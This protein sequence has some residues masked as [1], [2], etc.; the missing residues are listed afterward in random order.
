[1]SKSFAAY[2]VTQFLDES[3]GTFIDD[4]WDKVVDMADE[5][6]K[7]ERLYLKTQIEYLVEQCKDVIR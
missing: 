7:D 3:I 6:D 5:D 1:M 4:I 2:D